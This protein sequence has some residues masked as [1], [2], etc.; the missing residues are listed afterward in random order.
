MEFKADTLS[1]DEE[2]NKPDDWD[3]E[4]DGEWKAPVKD[5]AACEGDRSVK[6]MSN[7]AYLGVW[8]AKKIANPEYEDYDA[9]YKYADFG[10]IGF[11]L[12]Q[13]KGDTIIDNVILRYQA[14][15]EV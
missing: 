8:E 11:D 5:N 4:Q 12:S 1:V 10:F 9:V 15:Y 7:P 14:K 2:A 3:D 13:V 6:R